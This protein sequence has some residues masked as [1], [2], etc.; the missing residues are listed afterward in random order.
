MFGLSNIS[1]AVPSAQLSLYQSKLQQARRDA[2]QAQENVRTLEAQTDE[3]R[4]QAAQTQDEVNSLER[5]PPRA[6]ATLNTS[7]QFTGGLLNTTA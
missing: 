3:A 7:G 2:A 5:R 4:Q 6:Q 1:N